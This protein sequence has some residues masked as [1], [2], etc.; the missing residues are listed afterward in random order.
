MDSITTS[1]RSPE[2]ALQKEIAEISDELFRAKSL[3]DEFGM[4]VDDRN[5][6]QVEKICLEQIDK[7]SEL[8]EAVTFDKDEAK[9]LETLQAVLARENGKEKPKRKTK[10][11]Y[12]AEQLTDMAKGVRQ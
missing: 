7:L 3:L 11:T 5:I 10:S 1:S 2:E 6:S 12:S 4:S 8:A 9:I